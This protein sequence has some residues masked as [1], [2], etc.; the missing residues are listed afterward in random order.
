VDEP[1]VAYEGSTVGPANR[2]YYHADH[3]GSVMAEADVNGNALRI[4]TYDPYGVPATS[5]ATRFQYTGQIMLP[6]LGL[7]HYKARIYNPKLGRFMQT[8]PIGYK[9]DLDLYTYVGDDPMNKTDPDGK[10]PV[11]ILIPFALKALDAAMTAAEVYSAAQTGGASAVAGVLLPNLAGNII[12]GGKVIAKI[13]DKAHDAVSAGKAV[14]N[15]EHVAKVAAAY[16]RPSGATTV[17]HCESVQGK[18]CVKCGAET[19]K[20]VAGH[21]EALVKEH[22][23]TGTIDKQKMRSKDAVQ[24]ECPS[25]S[26]REGAEMSRYSRQKKKELDIE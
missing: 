19:P 25:C 24:A 11:V 12:P 2:R 26:A 14:D 10:I 5:N 7:Y 20:Q 13:A 8:D 9:D 15:T 22:Y 16:K 18:P 21:K 23:E 3:Q 6:D 4:N 1:L 17:A